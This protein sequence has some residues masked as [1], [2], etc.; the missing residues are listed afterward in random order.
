L[1]YSARIRAQWGELI[2]FAFPVHRPSMMDDISSHSGVRCAVR[3]PYWG[4]GI[5]EYQMMPP[6]K[7]TAPKA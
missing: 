2:F 3:W 5:I 4:D 6:I 7:A 1:A